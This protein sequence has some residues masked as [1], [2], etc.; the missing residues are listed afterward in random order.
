MFA[1]DQPTT[2]SIRRVLQDDGELSA[3]A[4]MRRHFP[5]LT[6]NAAALQCARVIAGWQPLTAPEKRRR[7][8]KSPY[9]AEHDV[10]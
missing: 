9:R 10:R 8:R 1:V 2:D 7:S 5:A 6:S 3:I 4:E